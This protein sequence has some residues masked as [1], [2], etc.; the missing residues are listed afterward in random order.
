MINWPQHRLA[1]PQICQDIRTQAKHA[2]EMDW[3][4]LR[5]FIDFGDVS[6]A[7]QGV[8]LRI[9]G[10]HQ[11]IHQAHDGVKLADLLSSSNCIKS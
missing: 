7:P 1:H 4:G 3:N 11:A 8:K 10:H 9:K 2:P 5:R 6:K